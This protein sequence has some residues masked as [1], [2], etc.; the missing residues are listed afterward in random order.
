MYVAQRFWKRIVG[1]WVY[2]QLLKY[3]ADEEKGSDVDPALLVAELDVFAHFR[4]PQVIAS[5]Q[6]TFQTNPGL[7]FYGTSKKNG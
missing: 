6:N 1:L 5:S 4:E 3:H 7:G 2:F